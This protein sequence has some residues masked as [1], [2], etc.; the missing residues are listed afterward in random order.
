MISCRL[1]PSLYVAWAAITSFLDSPFVSAFLSALAGAG[2]GAWAAQRIA[3]KEAKR[4]ELLSMLRQANAVLV[5]AYTVANNTLALK[6]Q[7]VSALTNQYLADR[8]LALEIAER[9]SRGEQPPPSRTQADFTKITPHSL[10][11]DALRNLM[12]SG[13]VMPGKALALATMVDQAAAELSHVI[14]L[15]NELIDGLKNSKAPDHVKWHD[16]Y[17][18][19]HPDGNTNAMYADCMEAIKLYTDDLIFFSSELAIEL[20]VFAKRVKSKLGSNGSD[21]PKAASVDFSDAIEKGLMPSRS[22]YESWLSGVRSEG[23][24]SG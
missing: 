20:S 24:T 17:G 10:P 2:V 19:K 7:H 6:N 21:V 15:R 9:L 23:E 8:Q 3:G 5:L 18:V 13:N 12:F 14:S 22:D 16:Y 11:L 1:D 4:A